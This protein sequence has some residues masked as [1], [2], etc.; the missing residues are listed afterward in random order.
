[1]EKLCIIK[2]G[3]N[4]IDDKVLLSSFL[5]DFCSIG[6]RKILVH[7]GGQIASEMGRRSGI[8]PVYIDGRRVTD[9]AAIDLVTMVYGGL[10]NKSIV[11]LLQSLGCNAFGVT[12]ADGNLI[13][14]IKRPVA[15]IDYGWVGDV[16]AGRIDTGRWRSLLDIG[17][18]PVVAPLTHDLQGHMLN[19][20]A[21]T[22]AALLATALASEFH[23]SLIYCF[24]KKGVLSDVHDES[25]VLQH[26][27]MDEYKQLKD[28]GRL[29]EGIL[30]KLESAFQAK[31]AGVKNVVIGSSEELQLLISHTAGTQIT[32]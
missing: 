4:V 19:T 9:D 11:A 2:I 25:S 28:E 3:G 13:P 8:E 18:T 31:A 26:L 29:F 1:M 14:A 24:E 23:L 6:G 27:G 7:G 21:D 10:V 22:V 32:G 5:H 16:D 30:P 17:F 15:N 12:G 20:N